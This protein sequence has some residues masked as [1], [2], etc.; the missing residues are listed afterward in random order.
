MNL[1]E[2]DQTAAE[3]KATYK[4]IKVYVKEET[5]LYVSNL[6]IAQ[7][8]RKYGLDKR[9]NYKRPKNKDARQ[10]QCSPEKEAAIMAALNTLI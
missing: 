4:E 8:K 1:D 9:P 10:P 7:V 5:G 2:M 3:S 6:C